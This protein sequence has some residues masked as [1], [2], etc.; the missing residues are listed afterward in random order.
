MSSGRERRPRAWPGAGMRHTPG[1]WPPARLTLDGVAGPDG[2][3]DRGT[4]R[5]RRCGRARAPGTVGGPGSS[6]RGAGPKE[7]PSPRGGGPRAGPGPGPPQ[8]DR[9]TRSP[10]RLLAA[11]RDARLRASR[12][13]GH[14]AG[15]APGP[16]LLP[17]ADGPAWRRQAPRAS[18]RR[19][20]RSPQNGPAARLLG[21][22]RPPCPAAAA[23]SLRLSLGVGAS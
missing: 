1:C 12:A 13:S 7:P 11:A 17:G 16:G 8:P 19:S 2:L 21:R 6:A 22:A 18:R 10:R 20:A 4:A 14:A 23:R 15:R 5:S 9:R 3:A